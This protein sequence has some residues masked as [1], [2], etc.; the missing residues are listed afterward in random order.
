MPVWTRAF[1]FRI[2]VSIQRGEYRPTCLPLFVEL[3]STVLTN[4]DSVTVFEVLMKYVGQCYKFDQPYQTLHCFSNVVIQL[5]L[6]RVRVTECRSYNKTGK[7]KRHTEL[8]N[9]LFHSLQLVAY[10]FIRCL[11][12]RSWKQDATLFLWRLAMN[13]APWSWLERIYGRKKVQEC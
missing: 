4:I 12:Y 3:L 13:G 5:K 1:G 11:T 9:R 10:M 6:A 7:Q 8:K 2:I